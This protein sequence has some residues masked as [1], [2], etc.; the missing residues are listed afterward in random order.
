MLEEDSKQE[1]WIS[2][3]ENIVHGYLAQYFGCRDKGIINWAQEI[4]GDD[5]FPLQM[6]CC[7]GL[8]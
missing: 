6:S 8:G 3:A 2:R 1:S 4:Q 7:G 5:D